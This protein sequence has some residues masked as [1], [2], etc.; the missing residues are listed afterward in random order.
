MVRD[1]GKRRHTPLLVIPNCGG[2]V[3]VTQQDVIA[4]D[5]LPTKA[6]GANNV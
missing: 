4:I 1:M 5:N 6:F 2:M 3:P